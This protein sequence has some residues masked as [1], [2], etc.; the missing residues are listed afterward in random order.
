MC[1][2]PRFHFGVHSLSCVLPPRRPF[3][4]FPVMAATPGAAALLPDGITLDNTLGAV[5]VGFAAACCVYGIVL[6]QAYTYFAHYPQDRWSY[7]ILARFQRCSSNKPAHM[8]DRS[9]WSRMRS[10]YVLLRIALTHSPPNSV[11]V[12]A[13]NALIAHIIYFYGVTNFANIMV[14]LRAKVT[15]CVVYCSHSKFGL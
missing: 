9:S 1:F 10:P 15:W 7:K 8:A 5:L 3:A 12:T 4:F 11:L 13:D 14:L 2:E 6:A